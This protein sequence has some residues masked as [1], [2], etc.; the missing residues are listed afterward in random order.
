MTHYPVIRFLSLP[1]GHS[2]STSGARI[3][4]WSASTMRN[5]MRRICRIQ[6]LGVTNPQRQP[7]DLLGRRSQDDRSATLLFLAPAAR[8]AQYRQRLV[9]GRIGQ[10]AYTM[11]VTTLGPVNQGKGLVTAK[12]SDGR[13]RLLL[14]SW[15]VLLDR[16]AQADQEGRRRP[17]V[18]SKSTKL[19]GLASDAIEGEE[20]CS[21]RQSEAS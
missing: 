18:T 17:S 8:T 7:V 9:V 16:L 20:P 14:T 19:R 11:L 3:Q 1:L 5:T 6:V 10:G 13:H 21:T 2:T 4:T 15:E 12:A